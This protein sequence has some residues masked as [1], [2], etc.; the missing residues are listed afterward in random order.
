MN[1]FIYILSNEAI[2]NLL[3]IGYTARTVEQRLKE[4]STT[5]V[6]GKFLIELYFEIENAYVFET[7]LH[8]ALHDYRYDKEFFKTDIDTVIFAVHNLLDPRK[9]H[10]YQFKG[11]ASAQAT[12][13][14]QLEYQKTIGDKKRERLVKRSNEL[15]DKFIG[16]SEH[17]LI[18][19]YRDLCVNST[20]QS[21]DEAKVVW[22]MINAI[23]E[24]EKASR[25]AKHEEKK[26]IFLESDEYQVYKNNRNLY[27]T[28][29][30]T[31]FIKLGTEVNNLLILISPEKNSFLR[32]FAYAV[33]GYNYEDGKKV[34]KALNNRQR[35]IILDFELI[36]S[37]VYRLTKFTG[38]SPQDEIFLN[39]IYLEHNHLKALE[40]DRH[41][42][43][44]YL[45]AENGEDLTD[46]FKG[47]LVGC[48]SS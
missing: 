3:K 25:L 37:D 15:R 11:K 26:R 28:K 14:E 47:I 4:L 43:N 42:N 35:K 19:T 33:L 16:K 40:I 41:S 27:E 10:L 20:R 34:S 21:L 29:I 38:F 24:E 17:E 13:R 46:Y 6:P 39:E 7:L 31:S 5:G 22:K 30:K 1:G 48:K 2:P 9:K 32:K 45:I 44:N 18:Q 8:K 23:R 12:T 36:L